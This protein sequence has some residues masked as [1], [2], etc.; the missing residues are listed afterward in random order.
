[1]NSLNCSIRAAPPISLLWPLKTEQ[2]P[3]YQP[4]QRHDITAPTRPATHAGKMERSLNQSSIDGNHPV[5]A[6]QLKNF[7]TGSNEEAD[8]VACEVSHGSAS[9]AA[10]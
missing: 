9:I 8:G 5:A 1:M 4:N 6:G 10:P 3:R 2:T 7:E